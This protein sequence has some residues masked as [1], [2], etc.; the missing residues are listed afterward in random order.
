MY[1]EY[2]YHECCNGLEFIVTET[3]DGLE[4]DVDYKGELLL[5]DLGDLGLKFEVN[6]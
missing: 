5:L 6:L 4:F 3:G 1:W 2:K